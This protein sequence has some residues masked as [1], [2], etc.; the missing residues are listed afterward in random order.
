MTS[1]TGAKE[2]PWK[3]KTPPG[4][5]EYEMCEEVK[6]GREIIMCA[7]GKTVLHYNARCIEDLHNQLKKHGDWME[8][9]GADEQK[10]ANEA[11][12]KRGDGRRIIQWVGAMD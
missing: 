3:L 9:G 6:D 5:P 7:E 1:C 8:L 10:P 4:A 11:A 12:L 2:N